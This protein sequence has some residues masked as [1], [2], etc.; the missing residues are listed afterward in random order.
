MIY[1]GV[2]SDL[3]RRVWQHRFESNSAHTLKY[4]IH[5]LVWFEETDD[6]TAAIA[7]EKQLKTW[8]RQWKLHLVEFEN[9]HWLDLAGDWY[10]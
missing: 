7:K 2:T 8:R 5:Q 9:P 4:G 3:H 6:V 10:G 1:T